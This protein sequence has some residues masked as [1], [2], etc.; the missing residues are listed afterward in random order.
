MKKFLLLLLCVSFLNACSL[1]NE[2]EPE[3][4]LEVLP[5]EGYTVSES[6]ETGHKYE[7]KVTY[8]RP[9]D[10]YFLDGLYFQAN[11]DTRTIGFQCRVQ[12]NRECLPIPYNEPYEV[13]FDFTANNAAGIPYTFKFYKGT[14]ATGNDIFEDVVIPVY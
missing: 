4:H 12:D 14:D 5:V 6:F 13:K 7:I 9:T 8:L 11:G 3:I 10:C 1:G 2:S